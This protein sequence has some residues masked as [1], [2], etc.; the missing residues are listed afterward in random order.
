MTKKGSVFI[1]SFLIAI[2]IAIFLINNAAQD[3]GI[4]LGFDLTDQYAQDT[5][6]AI[7]ESLENSGILG[8][9]NLGKEGLMD[10]ENGYWMSY[11][12][13]NVPTV[14]E[15]K[16]EMGEEVK[17][18]INDYL[19]YI[20][21]KEVSG[22][23]I[24]IVK[25]DTSI[26]DIITSVLIGVDEAGV[27]AGT[28]DEAF[29]ITANGLN[30]QIKYSPVDGSTVSYQDPNFNVDVGYW[31]FWL[32]YRKMREWVIE[33]QVSFRACSEQKMYGV[34]GDQQCQYKP[35]NI[36]EAIIIFNEEV[37]RLQDS[38]DEDDICISGCTIPDPDCAAEV[39]DGTC[40][41]D[42]FCK[43]DCDDPD[44]DCDKC[45]YMKCS[46]VIAC[47]QD[48]VKS[49][50]DMSEDSCDDAKES[51]VCGPCAPACESKGC[52]Y[53]NTVE[54]CNSG[55]CDDPFC[56]LPGSVGYEQMKPPCIGP[57][58]IAYAGGEYNGNPGI[59]IPVTECFG[60]GTKYTWSLIAEVTCD[61]SKYRKPI[62]ILVE[63]RTLPFKI[64]IH[65][66]FEERME[67]K[68][69]NSCD[70]NCPSCGG[71]CFLAGTVIDTPTGRKPIEE[72]S[73]GAEVFAFSDEKV[74]LSEVSEIYTVQRDYYYHLETDGG[75]VDV[76]AEHPFYI[77][78]GIFLETQ[79]LRAGDTVYLHEGNSLIPMTINLIEKI[80]SP[81]KAYN[82][83]VDSAHTFF[84]NGFAV[85]NKGG[86][87]V[88]PPSGGGGT[89][90]VGNPPGQG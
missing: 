4:D 7:Y 68:P 64:R 17:T 47:G 65:Q 85:H 48:S 38:F 86:G 69:G 31:R 2:V 46:Y 1:T 73:I 56:P 83:Q 49:E 63:S 32:I 76:T 54:D 3:A 78:N 53:Y 20:D 88:K 74:T 5:A 72:L 58:K 87:T 14:D 70:D 18:I 16:E 12:L 61:D 15:V 84:A 52:N 13:P 42:N 22:I 30:G 10:I 89:V 25:T 11:S 51:N 24:E 90:N 82:L 62:D 35:I 19:E 37:E 33:N 80:D 57:D 29:Q 36:Q 34:S 44:P 9:Y 6:N 55:A 27:M 26:E 40:E 60:V 66:Y 81:T 8:T 45:N 50:H 21:G 77:G 79:N 43:Q 28:Y 39:T 71:G 67:P 59:P 41:Q 75:N 23:G